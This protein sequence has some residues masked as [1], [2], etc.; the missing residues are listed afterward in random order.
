MDVSEDAAALVNTVAENKAKHTNSDYLRALLARRLQKIIGRPSL[1]TYLQIV[2]KKKLKNCPINRE[3]VAAAE[4]T[5]GPDVGTL[6]GKTVRTSQGR[7]RI[8]LLP[9]PA[10]IMDRYR[11][12]TLAADI[13][14]VNGVAFLVSIS[15]AIKFGTVELLANQKMTTVLV[16]I[17]NINN[18]YRHRGFKL[19]VL[20]M[21]GEFE[22]IRGE[23]AGIGITL[24]TVSRDEHVSDA[25]RRIRTV[26][27][28]S[29]CIFNTLPF[30]KIPAQMTVQMVYSANFWLN[31]F[32][33]EDGIS[34][35]NPRELI[36][37]LKID[38]EK[39]CQ[40]EYG[41][42]VQTHDEHDNSMAP[43]TTGAIAMRPT[44]NAQG[45]YW[46]YSLTAG[47]LLN[48]NHWTTLPMPADVIQRVHQLAK[49]TAPGLRFT[50]RLNREHGDDD[51]EPDNEANDEDVS[52]DGSIAGVDEDEL[53]DLNNDPNNAGNAPV[54]GEGQTGH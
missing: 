26:K 41:T 21:D 42:Y 50:D 38:Y 31:V 48:R 17:K 13:M 44:G 25:E 45:G 29:R 54:S 53:A 24:N 14:K 20:L 3:D 35:M 9:I 39:H 36:T 40:L 46:F 7:V 34:E 27:E 15:Q 49:S 18:L 30:K 2:E 19:D 33:P 51:Y 23:L 47:R 1:N 16:A 6:K 32:P 10:L 5:F 37:G 4:D 43:R 22:S 11:H 52:L 8:N 12:V 28:R